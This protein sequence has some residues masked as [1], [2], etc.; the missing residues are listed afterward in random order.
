MKNFY[1]PDDEHDFHDMENVP[2]YA[3]ERFFSQVEEV[4]YIFDCPDMFVSDETTIGSF[5]FTEE[6][7]ESYNH[8]FK[9]EWGIEI[10]REDY[11]WEIAEKIYESNF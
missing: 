4:L 2:Q 5:K 8:K 11:I 9:S 10:K 6:E 7:L 3:V 1:E